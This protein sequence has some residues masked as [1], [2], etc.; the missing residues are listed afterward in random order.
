MTSLIAYGSVAY[1]VGR[2]E[3][4]PT[5]QRTTWITAVLLVLGIGVSR[6]YLGVHYPSDVIGGYI[7]GLAWLTFVASIVS[8]IQYFADRR[9]ETRLEERDLEK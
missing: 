9:P 1:L 4:S 8:A 2:L 5:M 6:T 3:A 7:A